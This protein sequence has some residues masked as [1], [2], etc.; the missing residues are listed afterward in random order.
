MLTACRSRTGSAYSAGP[1]GPGF[2]AATVRV[3]PKGLGRALVR[4]C[5]LTEQFVGVHRFRVQTE[6]ARVGRAQVLEVVDDV[7]QLDRFF[8][9]R[10]DERRVRVGQTVLRRLQPAPDVAQRGAQLVGDIADHHLALL[11]QPGAVHRHV[12]E[13]RGQPS[14][15]VVRA[16]GHRRRVQAVPHPLGGAGEGV[17]GAYEPGSGDHR[18]AHGEGQDEGRDP[19]DARGVRR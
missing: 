16:D 12:V 13:G 2:G 14:D 8:E 6:R 3:T 1:G 19:D 9:E 7:L 5:D 11:L 15:L 17:Q 4:G 10:G 18:D